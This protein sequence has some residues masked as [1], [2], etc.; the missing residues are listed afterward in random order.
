MS[1]LPV[2]IHFM[3]QMTFDFDIFRVLVRS[4]ERERRNMD[5]VSAGIV[6]GKMGCKMCTLGP[7]ISMRVEINYSQQEVQLE[8]GL[9]RGEGRG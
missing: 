9:L 3:W 8:E 4:F 6:S 1:Y 5:F 2:N 7:R